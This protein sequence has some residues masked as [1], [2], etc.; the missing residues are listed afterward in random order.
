MTK[1]FGQARLL[2]SYTR[3]PNFFAIYVQPWNIRVPF[4]NPQNKRRSLSPTAAGR[5]VPADRLLRR[6]SIAPPRSYNGITT[7]AKL[8]P[9]G[10]VA[11]P[12]PTAIVATAPQST[13]KGFAFRIFQKPE[14]LVLIQAPYAILPGAISSENNPDFRFSFRFRFLSAL[15]SLPFPCIIM[16]KTSYARQYY[17]IY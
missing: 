13:V 17:Y 10:F 16:R 4:S 8:S 7:A 5:P 12:S 15:I 9:F 14:Q 6:R 1:N 2:Q 11:P 3:H